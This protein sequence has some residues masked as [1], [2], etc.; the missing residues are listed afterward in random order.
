MLTK[1]FAT[2]WEGVSVSQK[3]LDATNG[4]PFLFN[5]NRIDGLKTRDTT[6]SSF[7]YSLKKGDGRTVSTYVETAQSVATI[8]SN[9]ERTWN[10]NFV[11]LNFYTD[12]DTSKATFAMRINCENIALVERD[13]VYEATKSW[14]TWQE[15]GRLLKHLCSYSID[16]IYSLVDDGDLVSS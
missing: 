1:C 9:T 13:S 16:Q 7:M 10:S 5:G 3:V 15:G 12:D 8:V 6:E 2:K 14:V 11:L 4:T